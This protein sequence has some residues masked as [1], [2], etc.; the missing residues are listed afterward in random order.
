MEKVY[1][2]M[3]NGKAYYLTDA[4]YKPLVAD[5][6]WLNETY[7]KIGYELRFL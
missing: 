1:V 6:R 7:E 5:I 2:K 4:G 3:I